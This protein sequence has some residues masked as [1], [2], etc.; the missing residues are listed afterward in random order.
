MEFKFAME[1]AIIGAVV[2]IALSVAAF[3]ILR[4]M[5]GKLE[6]HL[7]NSSASSGELI[8]GSVRVVAK[9]EL[10]GRLTVSLVCMEEFQEQ[11]RSYRDDDDDGTKYETT[12]EEI[13]RKKQLLEDIE[14][15]S[16]TNNLAYQF[17]LIAP[18]ASESGQRRSSQDGGGGMVGTLLNMAT[19][20]TQSQSDYFW[21]VEARLDVKGIDL[22][23]K[24]EVNVRVTH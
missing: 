9:K 15:F 22:F 4:F 16:P 6:L 3:Y 1:Y 19:A 17:E 24:K 12:R 2:L 21:H 8:K 20:A 18:T 13:F 23:A 10:Q 14:T 7:T 11:K 5:K